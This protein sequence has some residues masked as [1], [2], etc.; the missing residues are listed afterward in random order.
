VTDSCRRLT[1]INQHLIEE[2][3]A[4]NQRLYFSIVALR[5]TFLILG[6]LAGIAVGIWIARRLN[7]SISEISV[8]LKDAS[9]KLGANLGSVAVS[10]SDELPELQ[11]QVRIVADQIQ[12]VMDKLEDARRRALQSERLAAV[13]ELA[14][15]VAHEIRNPLTSV[16]L[17]IQTAAERQPEPQMSPDHF[18]ILLQEISRMEATIQGLLDFARPPALRSISHDVRQTVRRGLNLIHGRAG[19]NHIAVIEEMSDSPV[20]VEGDPDQLS[21]V[22]VNLMLNAVEAMEKTGGTLRVSV[23]HDDEKCHIRVSDTGP[24]I[25]PQILD[26]IFEPFVTGKERGTGLGLAISRRV[27]DEHGG[28]LL[29]V[30]PPGGGAE[31]TIEL[32]LN[33]NSMLLSTTALPEE[34][35]AE[36]AGH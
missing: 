36:I 18:Q 5:V 30:N 34:T 31:L 13:G 4:T 32:N 14:A 6:P 16:K 35:H 25:P 1:E 2:Q 20:P 24:G 8:T 27:I 7:R 11:R 12:Q 17:L 22:L 21:L 26:R 3:I 33:Q 23:T 19:R 29:A 10:V 28:R 15:G 9:G